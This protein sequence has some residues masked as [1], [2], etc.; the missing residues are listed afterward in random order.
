M[1]AMAPIVIAHRG[2]SGH[3]PEHTL[4]AYELAARMGADYLEPDLVSTSD[5]VLVVRHEPEISGTTDVADR[6]EFADRRTTRTIDGK[7]VT[8]WFADDLTL[9]ELRTLRV[10][11]RIPDLRPANTAY[12]GR[13]AVPTF[14]EVLELT[15][16]LSDEL[17]RPIGVYPET[18]HPAYFRE[19]GLPLEPALAET[20]RRDDLDVPVYVQ[21]FEA[22]SL[23][24]V[25]ALL[26]V[27]RVRLLRGADAHD[28]AALAA[29]AGH[30]EAVG[31]PKTLIVP[32]D[33]DGR[34]LPATS[35]VTDAH[36]AGLLVH[37]WTFR[38]ENA[39]LAL[40][41]RS[42]GDRA[43]AGDLAAELRAF[44]ALGVD[45]VFCDQPDV[46]VAVFGAVR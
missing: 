16:A 27:P 33:A 45:G 34:S 39:F 19:R 8:G 35:F 17:G 5:G 26:D 28:A 3:R 24:E 1:P 20:L 4:E 44:V 10:R 40:E 25:G 42:S 37:P 30:A 2:A 46:A 23:V 12:D 22:D 38:A 36:A 31:P 9:A 13:F 7:A 41:L 32:R 18:K 21:S 14:G 6:P 15:R 11:E 29:I 43:A